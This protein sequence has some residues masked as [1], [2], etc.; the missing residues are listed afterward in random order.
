MIELQRIECAGC[1]TWLAGSFT[2]GPHPPLYCNWCLD[3]LNEALLPIVRDLQPNWFMIT[4][5]HIKGYV[6]AN[7]RLDFESRLVYDKES[8]E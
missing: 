4:L 3:S 7:F 2:P 1:G 8:K 6:A 5:A